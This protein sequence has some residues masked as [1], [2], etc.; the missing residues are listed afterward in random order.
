M[1]M[2]WALAVLIQGLQS[3]GVRRAFLVIFVVANISYIWIKDRQFEQRAA[4]TNRLI[5]QLK[6]RTP[7]DLA[8][9]DF[10]ANPWIA[11]NAA[12][13]V[14]GWQPGMIYVDP[15]ASDC[16]ACPTLRWDPR[17]EKYEKAVGR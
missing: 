15:P 13:T 1:G 8:I 11:K 16:Q 6:D 12:G 5:E 9:L 14:P 2:A 7:Q 3:P 4:P 10:P 17:A